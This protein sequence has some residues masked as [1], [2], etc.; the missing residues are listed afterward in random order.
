MRPMLMGRFSRNECAAFCSCRYISSIQSTA[1]HH[2]GHPIFN[3]RI[4]VA[5]WNPLSRRAFARFVLAAP[6]RRGLPAAVAQAGG[7]TG[8]LLVGYPAGG[9]L[10]TTARQLTE[11]WRKQGRHTSST[12]ASA[13]RAASR[14]ASSSASAPTPARLLCTHDFRTDDLSACLHAP[15]YDPAADFVPVSPLVKPPAPLRSAAPC[16]LPSR[17]LDDYVAWVRR[18]PDSA[19]LCIAGR[20]VDGALPGLSAVGGRQPEAA[21]RRLP[22]LG[23]GHAGSGRRPDPGVLRL[24]RRLP[25]LPAAGPH[26]DPGCRRG[27]AL[28]LLARG[29]DLR[30]TGFDQDSRR[31]RP[32]ASLR[33]PARPKPP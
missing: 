26:Q 21:A 19:T 27:E 20:R 33:H 15:M 29:A 7:T 25:A 4:E 5:P 24:R 22:R 28:R 10:D 17:T 32:T 8:K 6:A 9:T 16:P 14:A 18:T 11:A 31:R 13:P 2:C 1:G 23:A 12:T 3:P 30:R